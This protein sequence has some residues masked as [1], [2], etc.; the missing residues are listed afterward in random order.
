LLSI[1]QLKGIFLEYGVH[2]III[3][4]MISIIEVSAPPI[5]SNTY[6]LKVLPN[7]SSG[8]FEIEFEE[9]DGAVSKIYL[10]IN[11]LPSVSI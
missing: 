4:N 10:T 1:L 9:N 3:N 7:P 8:I 6:P 11:L 2:V 5:F